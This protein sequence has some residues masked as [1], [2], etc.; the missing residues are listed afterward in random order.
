MLDLT[1]A[2]PWRHERRDPE[3][4]S[5]YCNPLIDFRH[6]F[7]RLFDGIFSDCQGP[8]V[9]GESMMRSGVSASTM[10]AINIEDGQ[11]TLIVPVKVPGDDEKDLDQ[12]RESDALIIHGEKKFEYEDKEDDRHYI[13]RGD[14][15]F[16]S[17]IRLPFEAKQR[18]VKADL[19]KGVLT[20]RPTTP[21]RA[22]VTSNMLKYAATDAA[23]RL[24]PKQFD[25]LIDPGLSFHCLQFL[26]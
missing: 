2:V 7:D 16:S 13:E 18:H 26:P 1:L 10:P 19:E 24:S 17:S 12:T 11:K 9:N 14:G 23:N 25:Q 15:A 4:Y 6:K 3:V 21:A 20:V 5:S 22:K 8:E